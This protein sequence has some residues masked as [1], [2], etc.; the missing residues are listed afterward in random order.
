MKII[1]ERAGA[2]ARAFDAI[3]D[4]NFQSRYAE[5]RGQPDIAD[6]TFGNPHEM[7]LPG[8]VEAI[9]EGAIAQDKNWFAYKTNEEV[10]QTFLAGVLAR[11]LDLAFEPP[12]VALTAGAF[13]A[14]SVA[15]RLLLDAGDEVVFCEPGW[16]Y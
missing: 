4:F 2:A 14:I 13:A 15:F 1:S 12:D 3:K 6:F 11:E 10:P 7:P 16:F 8:L 9:R 5:R